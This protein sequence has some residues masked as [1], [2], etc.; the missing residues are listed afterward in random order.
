[1]HRLWHRPVRIPMKSAG[2]SG[3]MS[4]THSDRSRP[5]VPVDVGRGGGARGLV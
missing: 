5:A 3:L 2:D 1:L 4:A